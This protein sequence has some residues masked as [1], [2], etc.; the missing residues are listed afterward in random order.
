MVFGGDR[1]LFE[2]ARNFAHFFAHESCG[3]CTPCRVGTAL[4][5]RLMDKIA[6]GRGSRYEINEMMRLRGL[7]RTHEPL[8]PGPDGRQPV[9]RHAGEVP[10]GVTSGAC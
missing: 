7:M 9:R 3:F 1:D 10:P 6:E 5:T 8:R 4:Q 2:V